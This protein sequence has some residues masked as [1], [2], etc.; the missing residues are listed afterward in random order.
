VR[1]LIAIR[2]SGGSAFRSFQAARGRRGQNRREGASG[3]RAKFPPVGFGEN[4]A[5]MK[6]G[7]TPENTLL[8]V[9]AKLGQAWLRGKLEVSLLFAPGSFSF[10]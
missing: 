5:A 3:R 4:V 9:K 7:S 8:K 2:E 10:Q 6:G 1:P